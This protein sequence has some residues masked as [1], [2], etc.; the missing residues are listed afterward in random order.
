LRAFPDAC[1]HSALREVIDMLIEDG[2]PELD[3]QFVGAQTV[4]V[5]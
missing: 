4:T 2:E 5:G 3:A 1:V